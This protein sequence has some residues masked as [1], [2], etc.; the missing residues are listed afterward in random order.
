MMR[1]MVFCRC[2]NPNACQHSAVDLTKRNLFNPNTTQ[3]SNSWAEYGQ[4][5]SSVNT[6]Y[7]GLLC[8]SCQLGYGQT[9]A[10]TC[11]P[12]LGVGANGSGQVDRRRIWA[13]LCVYGALFTGLIWFTIQSGVKESHSQ[14][15]QASDREMQVTDVVKALTMYAQV[16]SNTNGPHRTHVFT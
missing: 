12:C 8:A 10:F 15:S 6:G 2:P 13:M 4:Q 11:D 1:V 7:T 9:D 5:L 16:S 3:L 14:L